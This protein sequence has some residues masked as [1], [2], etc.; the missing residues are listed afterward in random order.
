MDNKKLLSSSLIS[1]FQKI[2]SLQNGYSGKVFYGIEKKTGKE[3]V[4]K[5]YYKEKHWK[6]ESVALRLLKHQNIIQLVGK[7]FINSDDIFKKN[8][9]ETNF[10]LALEYAKKGDL[11]EKLKRR[12]YLFEQEVKDICISL[13][14]ALK[15]AYDKHGISH[16]DVKLENILEMKDGTIKLADWGLCSFDSKKK[17]CISSNGTLGYMAPEMLRKE[18]YDSQKTDVWSLGVVLFSLCTGN[19]P[20]GEPKSRQKNINDQSWKDE[21]LSAI[22]NNNM[23]LWWK[24]HLKRTPNTNKLS[25][26]FEDLIKKM[27]N[28][29]PNLRVSFQEIL[30]HPWLKKR[31]IEKKTNIVNCEIIKKNVKPK[32]RCYQGIKGVCCQWF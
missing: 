12:K 24:S 9:E 27:F 5:C 16:R 8:G 13:I 7:P 25:L 30:N 4:V 1:G 15:Y 23:E 29:N 6:T 26:E 21:W 19:R 11:Y 14:S 2:R 22:I 20:Y 10:I 18:K 28:S 3:V 17:E 32:N 31:F